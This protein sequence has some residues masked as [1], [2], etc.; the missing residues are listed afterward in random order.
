MQDEMLALRTYFY[1]YPWADKARSAS[2]R[3]ETRDAQHPES[4]GA[5]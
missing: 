5:E 3:P 1:C 2:D 4:G